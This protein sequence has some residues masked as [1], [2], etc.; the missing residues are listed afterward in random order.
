VP[1][2]VKQ[3]LQLVFAETM[4]DVLPVALRGFRMVKARPHRP[5]SG[6]HSRSVTINA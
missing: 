5:S 6:R 4:D 2:H 3:G 1:K